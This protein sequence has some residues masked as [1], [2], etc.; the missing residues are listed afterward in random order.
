MPVVSQIVMESAA[1]NS[2]TVRLVR[3]LRRPESLCRGHARWFQ[4]TRYKYVIVKWFSQLAEAEKRDLEDK[5]A[6]IGAF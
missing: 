1:G 5:I 6:A 3:L 4:P 2:T